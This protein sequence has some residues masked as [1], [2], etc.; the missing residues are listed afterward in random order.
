[1]MNAAEAFG[2]YLRTLR[3]RSGLSLSEVSQLSA[4]HPLPLDKGTLSRFERGQQ[5]LPLTALIPLSHSYS[6]SADVLMER[7]ELDTELEFV[8]VPEI[9]GQSYADLRRSGR[10]ALLNGDRKWEAYAY[11]RE[12]EMSAAET[13]APESRGTARLNLATVARA[14][15]KN[16]LA[17][18]ELLELESTG[19]LTESLSSTLQERIANCYRCVS[20]HDL[21]QRH[22]DNAVE[23]ARFHG[24]SR[25]LAFAQFSQGTL[26]VERGDA[27]EGV[28]RLSQAFRTHRDSSEESSAVALHPSF[29]SGTLLRIADAYVR[30]GA[31]AKAGR[32]ALAAKRL[33]EGVGPRGT[34]A[35]CEIA[36]GEVDDLTGRKDRALQRW[37]RA[38]SF[39]RE[40]NNRRVRFIA[41]FYTFRQAL[42]RGNRSLA[43]GSQKRLSR[44]VAWVPAHLSLVD[45]YQ[46]LANSKHYSGPRV[47]ATGTNGGVTRR[48]KNEKETR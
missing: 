44:L 1:M 31:H 7:L 28:H 23:Q 4:E 13:G 3:S 8:D 16:R 9:G 26:E 19:E 37:R 14:L 29:E 34:L 27:Q 32:A 45:E 30:L 21:A 10:A 17:L 33:A 5:R 48:A 46:E 39:G 40:L 38:E 43:Q 42:A 47:P 25:A 35:Y 18:H 2:R 11:F 36:L 24:D 22:L 41:E 15:G 20:E 12:A 6:C